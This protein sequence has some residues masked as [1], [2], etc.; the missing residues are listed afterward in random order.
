M[1]QK[2][3]EEK[4]EEWKQ[5][6][7]NMVDFCAKN[8][9]R[10]DVAMPAFTPLSARREPKESKARIMILVPSHFVESTSPALNIGLHKNTSSKSHNETIPPLSFSVYLVKYFSQLVSKYLVFFSRMK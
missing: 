9:I 1:V 5:D 6:L 8:R 7:W 10:P 2:V 3:K 4:T